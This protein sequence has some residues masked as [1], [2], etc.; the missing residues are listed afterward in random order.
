[1]NIFH[2]TFSWTWSSLKKAKWS[3]ILKNVLTSTH[4][5]KEFVWSNAIALL[6]KGIYIIV[7]QKLHFNNF[8]LL[9]ET[10]IAL[11]SYFFIWSNMFL[12]YFFSP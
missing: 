1:M 6:V 2:I 7:L 10:L 8:E 5:L 9:P 3:D 11:F 12:S 4:G